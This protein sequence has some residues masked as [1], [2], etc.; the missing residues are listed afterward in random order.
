[1]QCNS[2]CPLYPN[3]DRK[4]RHAENGHVCFKGQK[5]TVYRLGGALWPGSIKQC[6]RQRQLCWLL[7]SVLPSLVFQTPGLPKKSGLTHDQETEAK[8]ICEVSSFPPGPQTRRHE[9]HTALRV[10]L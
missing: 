1:M 7:F 9:R 4:S 5:R 8:P 3:S 10:W 2:P 6:R